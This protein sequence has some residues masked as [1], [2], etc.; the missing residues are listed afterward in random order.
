MYKTLTELTQDEK[1]FLMPYIFG[2]VNTQY[3]DLNDGISQGLVAKRIL[4]RSSRLVNILEGIPYNMQPVARRIL[5]KHPEL[6]DH[7]IMKAI[8]R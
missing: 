5:S 4:F 1:H 8:N 7:D 3:A 2:G 6:L